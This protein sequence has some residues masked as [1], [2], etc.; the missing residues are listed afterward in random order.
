MEIANVM[1]ALGGDTGNTVPKRGVTAAEIAVLRSIHGNEAVF[2][3]EPLGDVERSQREERGRLKAVYGR[4]MDGN[5]NSIVE[6][7]FPGA[8]ARLFEKIE[9]LEIDDS[10]YK[11]VERARAAPKAAEPVAPTPPAKPGKPLTAKQQAAAD[12]K[13]AAAAAAAAGDADD[14]EDGIGD[15]PPV[16]GDVLG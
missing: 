8:A 3:I 16:G 9:E 11:S 7:L 6:S 4:A 1:L 14:E 2:D 10:F 12:K 5:Q 13:A 15:L